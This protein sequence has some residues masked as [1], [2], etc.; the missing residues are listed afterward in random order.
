MVVCLVFIQS[1]KNT[2]SNQPTSSVYIKV[3]GIAQD[4]GYPQIN[5]REAC[6]IKVYQGKETKKLVSSLGVINLEDRKKYIFDA[7]PDFNLQS[8]LL[9]EDLED[10]KI[11]DG[12]FLTHAHMGHYTGLMQLGFESMN[13]D[14]IPVYAM[15]RMKN[16]LK[17]NGPWSQLVK[18]NNIELQELKSDSTVL[19]SKK[20]KVTPFL[21]PH[22][23]EFS[24]TVGYKIEGPQKSALF[25]PDINKWQLWSKSIVGKI[26]T[27][28]YAFLD[29]TFFKSGEINRPMAEVPHP[30]IE[31]TVDLF[32]NETAE[33]KQKVIFIHFNHTNPAILNQHFLKDSIQNLGFRFAKNGQIYDL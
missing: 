13:S 23:D 14:K 11:I 33:T 25:I 24:E 18:F 31:E 16:Y 7:T 8:Q 19:L 17:A 30:F 15:P 20:L 28:D 22:R 26:K 10:I 12:I 5:C 29:A 9:N 21:V 6:C 27:V 1:C 2:R 4:A 32:K 3:L